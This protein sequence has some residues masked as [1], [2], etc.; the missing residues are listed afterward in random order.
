MQRVKRL[1]D[2]RKAGHTGSLDPL[3]TGLLP[4]CFGHAT[5][6]STYLLDADKR[7]EVDAKFGVQ[8][9]TG[10]ADGKPVAEAHSEVSSQALQSA[11]QRFTGEID[12]V[13]PMYSALKHEGR[14]LY[15]L[16]RQGVVVE[17]KVRRISIHSLA[18]VTSTATSATL[19]VHCSKGTYVR[20][21][22]EDLAGALGTLGH[23]T[24]LRRT[25]VGP[26]HAQP[27]WT[28]DALQARREAA[29]LES[30]DELMLPVDAALASLPAVALGVDAAHFFANGQPVR[31]PAMAPGDLVRT[32]AEAGRFLGIGHVLEDGR[33][34]PKRLFC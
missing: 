10:D 17:R 3:A 26:F 33:L 14:R 4:V 22:V 24:R 6:I 13:P 12:Q 23:V 20:T 9:D 28:L 15:E 32:Y 29:G 8:T 19:A 31:V 11:L 7:Y 30:L 21:L 34:G 25:A 5:K 27:M 16:A 1:F 18:C 2:A